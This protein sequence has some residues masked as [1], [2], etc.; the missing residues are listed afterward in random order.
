MKKIKIGNKEYTMEF[1][2]AA[3]ECR[4][5]V[6]KMFWIIS[7]AYMYKR[8]DES[9]D[10]KKRAEKYAMLDGSADMMAEIPH[11]CKSAFYAGLLENH[12]DITEEEAKSLMKQ[13]MKEKKISFFKLYEE[14]KKV[15]EEDGFFDLS[16][17]TE[18][19]NTMGQGVQEN[20][21]EKIKKIPQDHKKKSTSTN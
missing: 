14:L 16:G 3:A 15:M 8:L 12:E 9:D 5:C 2:F 20:A 1:T 11:V 7:G 17:L 21:E 19:L 6:Q 18:M 4:E 10:D 13:Y